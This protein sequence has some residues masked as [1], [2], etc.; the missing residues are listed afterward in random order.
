MA[1]F[2]ANFTDLPSLQILHLDSLGDLA[3]LPPKLERL[4]SLVQ[5]HIDNCG[6]LTGIQGP[7]APLRRLSNLMVARCRVLQK[8]PADLAACPALASVQLR[9]LPCPRALPRRL[10]NTLAPSGGL[11]V[12]G[13][14]A[15]IMD[16]VAQ[17]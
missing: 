6:R 5:L 4:T 7:S 1:S 10:A 9:D 3:A 14:P 8:L 2:P 12:E 13:C 15:P 16:A 11:V 17:H